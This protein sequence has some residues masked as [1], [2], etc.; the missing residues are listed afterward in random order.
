M[1]LAC[2]NRAWYATLTIVASVLRGLLGYGIGILTFLKEPLLPQLDYW[3][4]LFEDP[5]MV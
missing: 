4:P 5:P 1:S 2:L 3:T